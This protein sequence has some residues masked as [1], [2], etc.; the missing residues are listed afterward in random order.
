MSQTDYLAD[1][2]RNQGFSV[3]VRG[4]EIFCVCPFHDESNPSFSVNFDKGAHCF[5]CG[6]K[7]KSIDRFLRDLS[8]VTG[9]E[10]EPIFSE[11]DLSGISLEIEEKEVDPLD[12][13]ALKYYTRDDQRFIDNWHVDVRTIEERRLLVDPIKDAECF[14]IIDRM[15]NFW[16]CVERTKGKTRSK[17]HYPPKI[18]KSSILLG[19]NLAEEEVWVVEGIRD[20]CYVESNFG[21]RAVALGTAIASAEQIDLLKRFDHVYVC[22]DNDRAGFL[23]A[24]KIISEIHPFNLSIIGYNG[25]DPVEMDGEYEIRPMISKEII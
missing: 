10:Y 6:Y 16:G 24:K 25:K 4:N 19:E 18:E 20:L 21:V 7:A 2:I 9:M 5:A 23:G 13:S 1:K 17:Y 8:H 11:G 14:P 22:L 15:G 3:Q 12:I